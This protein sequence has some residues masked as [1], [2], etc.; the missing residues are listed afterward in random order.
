MLP[1][2]SLP[3]NKIDSADR[4]LVKADWRSGKTAHCLLLTAHCFLFA[5]APLL[6]DTI[7]ALRAGQFVSVP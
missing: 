5:P 6:R 4:S 1:K 3:F 2:F 7:E